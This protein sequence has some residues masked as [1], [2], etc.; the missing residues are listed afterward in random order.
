VIPAVFD[1][2]SGKVC[3]EGTGCC[4]AGP[5]FDV[6][7]RCA[8]GVVRGF[9]GFWGRVGGVGWGFFGG[10]SGGGRRDAAMDVGYAGHSLVCLWIWTMVWLLDYERL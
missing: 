6:A 4:V 10:R 2:G 3:I 8:F 9:E 1:V 7:G 5:V